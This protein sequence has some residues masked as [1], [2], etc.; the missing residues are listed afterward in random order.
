MFVSGMY[1]AAYFE[2]DP[3]K[4]V[5][6]GLACIPAESPYARLIRDMLVS[7]AAEPEDWRK[8]WRQ[9]ENKWDKHDCCPD[10]V[11]S[12][13]NIDAKLNGG[14]IALG[15]LY[16]RG[17]WQQT[18]QI[19]TRCGQD[20]DCNP[21]NA[22]GILGTMRGYSRLPEHDREELAKLADTKFR[23]TD[24]SLNDIVDSSEKRALEVIRRNGGTV[25]EVEVVIPLQTPQPP[26]LELSNFGVPV[27]VIAAGDPAWEWQGNW[28]ESQVDS[29][30]EKFVVRQTAEAGCAVTLT[31]DG[32]GISLVGDLSD[33]GGRAD[34]F[35]DGVKSDLVADAYAAPITHDNDLWHL[36]GLSPGEHTLRLVMRED[37]D[38]HS[39]GHQVSIN[40]AVVYRVE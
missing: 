14:Y 3:R 10:G 40:R 33:R 17:D 5:E 9:V 30:G 38:P 39:A 35:I 2:D 36:F 31:F 12:P 7:S 1:A 23:H 6:A 20:S 16:G 25:S 27:Q 32:T 13:F 26:Q 37:A 29:W 21:S 34:V 4:V 15:L 8:V 11:H 28:S 19:A 24:Y 18:L 22:L